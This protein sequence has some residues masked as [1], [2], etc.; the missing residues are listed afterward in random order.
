MK[1]SILI[2]AWK[3]EKTI[4]KC[5]ETFLGD[6]KGDFEV[7]LAC[8]DGET[9]AA[10]EEAMQRQGMEDHLVH[11]Q[12]PGEGKPAALNMLMEK[13]KGEI[14]FFGDGDVFYGPDVIA[15]ILTRFEADNDLQ[16]ITGRPVSAD[17]KNNM[18]GY[19]GNLLADAAHHKRSIDLGGKSSRLV[20]ER[21]FF[22]VSG[23]LYAMRAQQIELPTDVLADDGYISYAIHDKGGKI[24]YEPEALV[25]VKYA[26]TLRDYLKQ[27]KRSTGGYIQLWQYGFVSK[28]NNTRSLGRELE[29][30]W[31]PIKYAA[32]LKQLWW[33]VL[34]YPVRLYMWLIIF[35]ERKIRKKDFVK[36]WV[37]IESTK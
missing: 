31:F 27:K 4:G 16:A 13:A 21:P 22:P 1:I 6:Y 17:S 3:E 9:L 35:W 24:G 12:D 2:T 33:S 23:Y 28:E 14:W 18:M 15:K 7:L 10:A 36:T 19:W 5:I 29:Y 8:P 26:T 20:K 34:M 11:V 32:N 30:A 25:Y 37:R